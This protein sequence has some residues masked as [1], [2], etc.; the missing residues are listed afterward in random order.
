MASK[1]D[2]EKLNKIFH[3]LDTN[4]D[5]LISLPELLKGNTLFLLINSK[6]ITS[7]SI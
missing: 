4:G 5:G 2:K 3:A 7:A 1:E 6:A